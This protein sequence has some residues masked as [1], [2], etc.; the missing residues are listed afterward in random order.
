MA[1]DGRIRNA[2]DKAAVEALTQELDLVT[3]VL[4]EFYQRL[5]ENKLIF[6]ECV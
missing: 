1:K 2:A 6:S 4:S 5:S 3:V